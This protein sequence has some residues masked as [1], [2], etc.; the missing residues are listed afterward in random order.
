MH[1]T[2]TAISKIVTELMENGYLI[3]TK[4]QENVDLGRNPIG[5]GIADT[6]PLV[7]GILI[8]R[9]FCEAVLCNLKLE[10]LRSEKFPGAGKIRRN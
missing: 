9:D 7:I 2:K 6:A 1:L 4:K 8:M 10:I 5:L 3:E